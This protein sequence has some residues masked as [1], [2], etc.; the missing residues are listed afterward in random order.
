MKWRN[1]SSSNSRGGA[2]HPLARLPAVSAPDPRR[3]KVGGLIL[4]NAA[5]GRGV[6]QAEPYALAAFLN[7]MQRMA[8][9]AAA[10]GRRFRTR[11]LHAG[12]RH[13][14]VSARHGIRRGGRSELTRFEGEV[15]AREARALGVHWVY[16]RWPTST[17][18][19]TTRSSTSAPSAKTRRRRGAG[20]GLHRGRAFR[21]PQLRADH[22][23]AFSGPRRHAVDSH[24][25]L[26]TVP[27][28]A[29][30]WRA[31]NWCRSAPP[32]PPEWTR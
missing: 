1:W 5:N 26:A 23:Q 4:T 18:T 8:K 16:A 28:D 3:T 9:R 21:S 15:T 22:G 32:S 11:R 2:Q 27:A 30:G 20:E 19:P 25:N 10:G 14:R 12:L 24:L 13:H 7:R 29:S 17:T 6:Q 31:W